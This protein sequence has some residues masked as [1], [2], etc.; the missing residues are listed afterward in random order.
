MGGLT[1]EPAGT[2]T[3]ATGTA[4][5]VTGGFGDLGFYP[6]G[7]LYFSTMLNTLKLHRPPFRHRL[8]LGQ[9]RLTDLADPAIPL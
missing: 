2:V 8:R 6:K 3:A 9:T 5:Q 4:T 7:S 1:T